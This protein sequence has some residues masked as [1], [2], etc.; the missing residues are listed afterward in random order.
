MALIICRSSLGFQKTGKSK[1]HLLLK[2]TGP[3]L[4]V[5][6]TLR[7]R[8]GRICIGTAKIWYFGTENGPDVLLMG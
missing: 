3:G 5:A 6:E 7:G 4:L 1:A 8:R 2:I